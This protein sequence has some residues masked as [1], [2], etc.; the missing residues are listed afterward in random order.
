M[1]SHTTPAEKTLPPKVIEALREGDHTAFEKLYYHYSNSI[2]HFLKALTRS[3][4]TANDIM[5]ETFATVWE[6]REQLDLG[7][8]IKT[9][10]YTIARN[11]TIT[12]FNREK[13]LDKYISD[14][15]TGNNADS[16]EEL[17]IAKETDLLIRIIV[18]RMPK[19]RQRVFELSRYEGRTNEEI[20][21]ELNISKNNVYDHLY[22]ATKDIKE[23]ISAFLLFILAA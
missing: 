13:L 6:K 22:Q 21:Q 7:K 11:K 17:L 10:L 1:N 4:E 9:Y 3:D 12:Y 14:Y 18:S 2:L 8:N 15:D 5:Q 19:M 23:V 20:A 16:S